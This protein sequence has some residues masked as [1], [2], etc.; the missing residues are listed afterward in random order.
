MGF[1]AAAGGN[2]GGFDEDRHVSLRD[3]RLR[4]REPSDLLS[5][6]SAG[7]PI[8]LA[9]AYL[10]I[11]AAVIGTVAVLVPHPSYFNVTGLL[12]VQGISLFFGVLLYLRAGRVPFWFLRAGPA[13]GALNT[14]AA[15]YFSGDSTS[16]FAMFYLWVGLYAFY[17]P[18]TKKQAMF[19]VSFSAISYLV[20]ILITPAPPASDNDAASYFV[21]AA[22]TLITA[23]TLLTYLRGRVERLIGR[24]TDSARTDPLTGLPNRAGFYLALE[25]ELE[26]VGSGVRPVSILIL[27]VDRFKDVNRRHGTDAGDSALQR[28]GALLEES[29]RLIDTVA[30]TAGQEFAILLPETEKHSAFMV[31]EELVVKVR[32]AFQP[33]AVQ[34]TVSV[35]AASFPE[36]SGDAEQL[37]EAAGEAVRA[38]KLLGRDRPVVY[39]PEVTGTL[40]SAASVAAGRGSVE[41]QASLASVLG[42]AEALDLRDTYTAKHSQRVGHL[43]ELTARELR[44]PED[45]V[46]RLR[47]AGL[48]HDIG[49]VAVPDAVVRKP[50]PLDDEE[51]EQMRRHPELGAR[52]LSGPGMEDLREWVLAH[53]E[54]PD[55]RGY[56]RGL[57]GDE[58]PIEAAV[59]AAA[60]SYEAMISDR[61][62]R[63]AIGAEAA[64]QE[65]L[66]LSGAQFDHEVVEALISAVTKE[67]AGMGTNRPSRK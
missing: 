46:Q 67:G 12:A 57:E 32:E 3:R 58:I 62:Y 47:L 61:V 16:G 29:K 33:P 10:G 55:G 21:I 2:P 23:G 27:D 24:L 54:Q 8:A 38:A 39:S 19:Y 13:I 15:V 63:P 65:L 45:K 25:T 37:F 35:G 42:L 9:Q 1:V 43:C 66:N 34:I 64:T 60:D 14:T 44:M 26:R 41:R 52:I 18:S 30:R 59:L 5:G 40:S 51:R 11:G 17:F 28:L 50:G 56:P 22:G 49:K 7:R 4:S 20:A 53:H 31:A 48:L 36:H 6:P